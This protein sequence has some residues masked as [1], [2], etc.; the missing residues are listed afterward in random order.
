MKKILAIA[1]LVAGVIGVGVFFNPIIEI[2]C[3]VGGLILSLLA[4]DANANSFFRHVRSW[5]NFLA[6]L[7]IIWV[8]VEFALQFL[9]INLFGE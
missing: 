4:K 9:G 2:A 5:G 8:C 3:G 7:N 6:W 1:S